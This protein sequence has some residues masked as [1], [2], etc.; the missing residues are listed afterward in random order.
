MA[1][2]V[3]MHPSV[4]AQKVE[5]IVEHFRTVTM[6]R[7]GGRAKAMVVTNSREQAVRYKLAFDEYIKEKNIQE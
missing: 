7:I 4:I 5:I 6:H 1:R 3:S 2:F